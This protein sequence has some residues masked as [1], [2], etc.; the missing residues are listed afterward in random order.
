MAGDHHGVLGAGTA[1]CI[2]AKDY[3]L[4]SSTYSFGVTH[5]DIAS[6]VDISTLAKVGDAVHVGKC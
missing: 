4:E 3:T 2:D 6:H 5:C 1:V